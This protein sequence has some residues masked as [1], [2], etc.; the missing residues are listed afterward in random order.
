MIFVLKY[1]IKNYSFKMQEF[2]LYGLP[3]LFFC[4]VFF[5]M[6]EM[7]EKKDYTKISVISS[8]I[9]VIVFVIIKFFPVSEPMMT[10][11]YFD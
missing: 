4:I 3:L 2:I 11:N 1:K 7:N 5:V 9:S 10:G 8:S 6:Y